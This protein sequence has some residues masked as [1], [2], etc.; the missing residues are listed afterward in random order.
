[1]VAPLLDANVREREQTQKRLA[2][3]ESKLGELDQAVQTATAKQT[4]AREQL[5]MLPRPDGSDASK[6]EI[7]Q[8]KKELAAYVY[9]ATEA[10]RQH[11]S[12]QGRVAAEAAR[13]RGRLAELEG[14]FDRIEKQM[15]TLAAASGTVC[16]ARE[17]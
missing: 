2:D 4:S 16:E 10:L 6:Q 13:V 1:V 8:R 3:L 12:E 14:E 15:Q 7:E 17:P 5:R 11:Q 9:V